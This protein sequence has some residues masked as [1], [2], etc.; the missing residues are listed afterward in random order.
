LAA[1]KDGSQSVA[2]LG[3]ATVSGMA[4]GYGVRE[5][6]SGDAPDREDDVGLGGR[7]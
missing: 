5:L 4:D 1:R 2:E 7:E 3:R 6:T